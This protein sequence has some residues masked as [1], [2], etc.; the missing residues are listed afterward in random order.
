MDTQK[1]F[2]IE[3]TVYC[4]DVSHSTL[5]AKITQQTILEVKY[6]CS[7][8]LKVSR[9]VVMVMIWLDIISICEEVSLNKSFL[10]HF[11]TH[12]KHKI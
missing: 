5:L 4:T 9:L 8:S 3:S 6:L 10:S 7:I 1:L 11:K 2:A 12:T